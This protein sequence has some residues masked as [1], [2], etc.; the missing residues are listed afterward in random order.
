MAQYNYEGGLASYFILTFLSLVL[1]P[2]TLSFKSSGPTKKTVSCKCP[3]CTKK[4]EKLK[5][6]GVSS[7]KL[8]PKLLVTIAL[9]AVFGA[10][11]YNAATTKSDTKIYNP[12]EILGIKAGTSEKD[13]KR[14][15]KKLSVKF[16][17]DKVKLVANQTMESVAAHFVELTKAYKSLTDETVR[18]N[19]EQY[20]HPDGKQEFSV[21]IAIPKW[22]VEGKNSMFVLAFYGAIFMGILPL[23]VGRWWFGSRGLTKDGVHG[24]TASLFFK[25][26]TED[27]SIDFLVSLLSRGFSA[28]QKAFS[29][30]VA[31]TPAVEDDLNGLETEIKV[32]LGP[33]WS[34]VAQTAK[35]PEARRALV[36]LYAHLLRLPVNN[37]VL[38]KEQATLILRAPTLLTSLLTMTLSRNWAASSLQLMH[39]HAYLAQAILPSPLIE[40]PSTALL[41][42]PN[43]K[44]EDTAVVRSGEVSELLSNLSDKDVASGVRAAAANSGKL[45]IIDA[46]FKVIGERI[47]TPNA[48]VN[49]LFRAQV[50]PRIKPEG[51]EKET[52]LSVEEAKAAA[53]ALDERENA[54]LATRHETEPLDDEATDLTKFNRKPSWW[55]MICNQ[56]GDKIIFGPQKFSDVPEASGSTSGVDAKGRL[57]KLQFQSP[58]QVG[59]YAFRAVFV[60]D[61]F[62]GDDLAMDLSLTVED[63]SA[64]TSEEA[65][66]EDE[67][68]DPDE[69]TLAG[70]MAAMRGG[71]VKR[72]ADDESEDES[73][74]DGDE[75]DSSDDSSD[76]D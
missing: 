72:R 22:V 4:E 76:D 51:K 71:A 47:V 40:S 70:Q 73:D 74:T 29:R 13:I 30:K 50:I 33:R 6:S 57:Y 1:I 46:K 62:V 44:K 11:A 24:N 48:I 66:A 52:E 69:D 53:K 34:T 37:D 17:P 15:Y 14:H 42:Y 16:H 26:V 58:P 39:L 28:E 20:G 8:G 5:K 67:I 43:V 9:W 65:G 61:T 45:D 59:T 2:L 54:F 38:R 7:V 10:V 49:L 56:P 18:Q 32:L 19:L 75:S 31:H 27:A 64:L 21:G 41:Q 3:E 60:S 12:F 25:G 23:V 36:L 68:S 63:V 35:V 55:V